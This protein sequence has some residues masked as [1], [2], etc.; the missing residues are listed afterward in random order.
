MREA[1]G[2]SGHGH[3]VSAGGVYFLALGIGIFAPH[4][5]SWLVALPI[6]AVSAFV[7]WFSAYRRK[8]AVQDA[9]TS[10]IATAA[11]GYVELCGTAEA[12]P[13]ST[14]TGPVSRKPCVWYSYGISKRE[15]KDWRTVESGSECMPFIIRD[16]T[17][18]CLVNPRDAEVLCE[19]C[20]KWEAPR[21]KRSEW[22]IRPGDPIYAIGWFATRATAATGDLN[23]D[24]HTL[25]QSW[26]ADA[27]GFRTRFDADRD[28]KVSAAE[29]AA[30]REVARRE[31]TER[32][33]PQG[34]I[35]TLRTPEDG[36][37]FILM[38]ESHDVAASRFHRW[39]IVHLAIF[40]IALGFFVYNLG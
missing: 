16:E 34:G 26:V 12:A 31:V 21:E 11:Q 3:T 14:L 6:L 2:T 18:E 9:P 36:R 8:R 35:H 15:G 27:A 25:L 29:L 32:G 33:L 13:G 40:F 28:G 37:P 4:P 22:S 39:T 5:G 1:S 19:L 38:N 30:A 17:G 7:Y 24:A 20:E 23:Q 10:K